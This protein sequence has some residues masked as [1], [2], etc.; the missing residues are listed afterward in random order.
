MLSES[1]CF[2]LTYSIFLA[3]THTLKGQKKTLVFSLIALY[4][5][6][7][8]VGVHYFFSKAGDLKDPTFFCLHSPP[9]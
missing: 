1:G 8:G 7:T 3:E 9:K 4:S 6:E 2:P 5:L